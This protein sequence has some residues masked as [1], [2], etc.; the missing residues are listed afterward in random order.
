MTRMYPGP[1][2]FSTQTV[3]PDGYPMDVKVGL[4][5]RRIVYK[6]IYKRWWVR[7]QI[8]TV[9]EVQGFAPKEY[10]HL[11][12]KAVFEKVT[13]PLLCTRLL[14]WTPFPLYYALRAYLER[15]EFEQGAEG[16]VV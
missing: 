9:Y 14:L 15:L 4:E 10:E 11:F 16:G 6:T 2:E 8:N 5:C 7:N 3:R 1:V 12:N 13:Y